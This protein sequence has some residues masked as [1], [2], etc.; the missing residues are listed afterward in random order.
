M[1]KEI[2]EKSVVEFRRKFG[3]NCVH[4]VA[5]DVTSG[6][7]LE[8]LLNESEKFFQAPVD[9]FVNNAGIYTQGAWLLTT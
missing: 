1:N 9:I 8:N 4:F 3:K 6:D 5:C 2:G 7:Q